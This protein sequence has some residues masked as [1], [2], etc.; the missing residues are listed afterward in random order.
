[1]GGSKRLHLVQLHTMTASGVQSVGCW[2]VLPE[3]GTVVQLKLYRVLCIFFVSTVLIYAHAGLL[4]LL[5]VHI[6]LDAWC[7]Q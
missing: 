7:C 1:M 2:A 4:P 3:I 5:S 6:Q